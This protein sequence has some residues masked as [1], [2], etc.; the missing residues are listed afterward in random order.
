MKLTDHTQ[1]MDGDEQYDHLT[2]PDF[3]KVNNT[4]YINQLKRQNDFDQ[5]ILES[6]EECMDSEGG[7]PEGMRLELIEILKTI[8]QN[9]IE[10]VLSQTTV[11]KTIAYNEL[12]KHNGDLIETIVHI[13]REYVQS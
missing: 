9:D 8:I 4:Q 2:I 13:N 3:K 1:S 6:L 11:S 7:S 5:K 10:I 12:I